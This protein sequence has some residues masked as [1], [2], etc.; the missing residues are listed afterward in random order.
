MPNKF[1]P[2]TSRSAAEHPRFRKRPRLPPGATNCRIRPRRACG[3]D[4][5]ANTSPRARLKT[6]EELAAGSGFAGLRDGRSLAYSVRTVP[7]GCWHARALSRYAISATVEAGSCAVAGPLEM[8]AP[9]G[10]RLCQY[11]ISGSCARAR[12]HCVTIR[13]GSRYEQNHVAFAVLTAIS[14]NCRPTSRYSLTSMCQPPNKFYH[15][16]SDL[17]RTR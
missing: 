3:S 4:C 10:V 2:Q 1:V 11:A 15:R 14:P 16:I 8:R 12:S 17:L 6:C 13:P 7:A 9:E 5:C